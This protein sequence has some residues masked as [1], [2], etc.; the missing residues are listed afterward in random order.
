VRVDD[1]TG[2][3]QVV[4]V[5]DV[6]DSAEQVQRPARVHQQ[7]Q[8]AAGTTVAVFPG[9]GAAVTGDEL[10]GRQQESAQ[11][12]STVRSVQRKVQPDVQAAIAEVS[13]RQS[14]NAELGHQ[15]IEVAQILS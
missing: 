12:R 3:E 7:E 15:G 5:E 1:D 4:G 13:V 14:G 6:F 10:A 2:I 11:D 8:F 9:Q